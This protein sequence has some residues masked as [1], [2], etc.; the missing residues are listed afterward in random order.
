LEAAVRLLLFSLL[1]ALEV[2]IDVM[3]FAPGMVLTQV[4]LEHLQNAP[5][6]SICK[7][8]TYIYN[9]DSL[10]FGGNIIPAA[11]AASGSFFPLDVVLRRANPLPGRFDAGSY[12]AGTFRF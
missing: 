8:S 1:L 2:C 11:P 10:N 3:K 6:L 4:T 7:N 12:S 9:G 5:G